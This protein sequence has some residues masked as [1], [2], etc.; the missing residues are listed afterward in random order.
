[1]AGL[2]EEQGRGDEERRLLE[3]AVSAAPCPRFHSALANTLLAAGLAERAAAH[4]RRAIEM[5]AHNG[6]AVSNSDF[7]SAEAH[8]NLA[9]ALSMLGEAD[10]A[11]VHIAEALRLQP[12]LAAVHV[13]HAAI[14]LQ[15]G[16]FQ[17]GWQEFEWRRRDTC[18]SKNNSVV[19]PQLPSPPAPLPSTGEG[20]HSWSGS[21]L[22]NQAI[23]LIAEQGLG[24]TLQFSRFAAL[25]KR[26]CAKTVLICQAEL[27]P[28]LKGCEGVDE[29]RG[30]GDP[31]PEVAAQI[32][33]MSLPGLLGTTLDSIPAD[34]PYI[35][36][37]RELVQTWRERLSVVHSFRAGIA[38]QGNPR[39]RGDA[40]RS[41]PLRAFLPLAG[42]PGVTLVSLQKGK[43][44]EQAP[45]FKE[46]CPLVDVG[47]GL[48]CRGAFTDTAA[49]LCNLDLLIT[50][51]SA[52]AHL[53]GALGVPVWIAL[54]KSADWRWLEEREDCPWYPTMRLF[55]QAELGNWD[56][57]FER[58]AGELKAVV[59]GDR[60]RLLPKGKT[61]LEIQAPIGAGEL[62]DRITILEIKCRRASRE[63]LRRVAQSELEQLAAV[64]DRAIRMT[65]GIELLFAELRT[66]NE[67]LWDA[68]DH[69]RSCELQ[70]DFGPRFV[71][72]ARTIYLTNDSRSAIKQRINAILG[73]S[74]RDVKD[75]SSLK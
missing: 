61:P 66:V 40:L 54:P 28:I 17:V 74:V 15:R 27:H 37:D 8:N 3:A 12:D 68:E 20:S 57:L 29:L 48:D 4:Y 41:V 47:E 67:R 52:V 58:I 32:P 53:A 38:W 13:N 51:D 75:Y 46:Q 6:P 71:E 22:P 31:L 14:C 36:A 65:T 45:A 5:L 63:P 11:M 69:I 1:L 10:A 16:D 26:L 73:S 19:W 55:R 2:L 25:V 59:D 7:Q 56:A 60:S 34:V 9:I 18:P 49:I 44:C 33:L 42:I 50:S 64:R 70:H 21:P 72:L 30:S 24:D 39:Y 35:K 23:A 62:L 43:G